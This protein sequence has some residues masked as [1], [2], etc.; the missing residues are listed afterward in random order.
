MTR[1]EER[2]NDGER[3]GRMDTR[4]EKRRKGT[5]RRKEEEKERRWEGECRRRGKEVGRG[6][7]EEKE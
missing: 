3:R 4:R 2:K 5:R 6:V 7:Q 1:G